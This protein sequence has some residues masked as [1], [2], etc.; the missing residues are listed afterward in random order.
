MLTHTHAHHM[1]IA[2]YA[3]MHA[4]TQTHKH[5]HTHTHTRTHTRTHTHTHTHTFFAYILLPGATKPGL[6]INKLKPPAN[7]LEN[8]NHYHN[9]CFSAID[10]IPGSLCLSLSRRRSFSPLP[11]SPCCRGL[12]LSPA[13]FLYDL[14]LTHCHSSHQLMT[15]FQ[16]VYNTF[17]QSWFGNDA[18]CCPANREINHLIRWLIKWLIYTQVNVLRM[19]LN[20]LKSRL[21]SLDFS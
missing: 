12:S 8:P 17:P 16:P 14:I 20:S 21:V 4:R 15:D 10:Y 11:L 2:Y 5:T 18:A 7:E 1:H 13:L 6:H 3:R 9:Y 19:F